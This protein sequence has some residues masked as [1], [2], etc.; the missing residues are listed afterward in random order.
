MSDAD[1]SGKIMAYRNFCGA[2]GLG[3]SVVSGHGMLM[4]NSFQSVPVR[5]QVRLAGVVVICGQRPVASVTSVTALGLPA[6]M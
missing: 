5:I 1:L 2:L 4:W 3:Q 6:F